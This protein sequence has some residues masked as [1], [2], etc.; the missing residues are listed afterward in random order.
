M[1][2]LLNIIT[3]PRKADIFIGGDFNV[4]FNRNN[5]NRKILKEIESTFG[6]SQLIT[7]KTRPLWVQY[8]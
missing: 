3:L 8:V 1:C 2:E 5:D 6:L 7:N 4:D